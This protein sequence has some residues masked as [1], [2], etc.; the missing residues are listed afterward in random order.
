G[1]NSV[2][3]QAVAAFKP[4]WPIDVVTP[5]QWL[6][7][8][9][10]QFMEYQAIIIGDAGCTSGTSAFQAAID[11]RHLWGPVIDG[12]VVIIGTNSSTGLKPQI[13]RNGIEH[14]LESGEQFR[15]SLY[16]SLGCAYQDAAA[17]TVVTL[18]D[19]LGD[20]RVQ[21]SASSCAATQGHIFQMRPDYLSHDLDDAYLG[22]GG[23]AARSAFT[24]Y[25]MKNFA[26]VAIGLNAPG[27]Q[28]Y[29]DYTIDEPNPVSFFGTPY[30]LVR[31]ALSKGSG[32]GGNQDNVPSGEECD[33]GDNG[34]GSPGGWGIPPSET[35][36]YSCRRNWCGDGQ[37]DV[38]FGEECDNGID[39][40]RTRDAQGDLINGMCTMSCKIVNLYHP[41]TALCR[42]VT[43]AAPA[44]ACGA[45][46]DINNGSTDPDDDL[47]SCTQSPAGPYNIGNTLVTL[48][49]TDA[50]NQ[51][52]Q[53]TGTVTVRDVTGPAVSIGTPNRTLQCN[54][55]I[56]YADLSDVTVSELC[57]NP[58]SSIVRSGSVP[59]GM[60]GTYPLTYTAR[61]AANNPGSA[62]RTVNVV[63]T[64]VPVIN[65][66]LP[67]HMAVECGGTFTD[68]GYNAID[69]C[70][71][72]LTGSVTREGTVN[73]AAVGQYPLRYNL[74]DPSGN[75]AQERIR[76]VN[77]ND[78]RAPSLTVL[79][80]L[81][82]SVQCNHT[83]YA[84]PGATAM[85]S[86]VGDLTAAIQRTG[87]VNTGAVGTYPL[88]YRVRDPSGHE[89]TG[90]RTVAVHDTLA[91][92]IQV[93]PG[94]SVI[95]CNGTPY[96]D[97][98][99][100]ASDLCTGDLTQSISV[101]S[102]LIQT[103]SGQYTVT[104]RVAD[105]S[106]NVTTAVRQ[107]T[108]G[109]CFVCINLRLNDY[110][111]FLLEDYT[112]GHDVVGKVAAGGNI[113][114]ENF[115]VGH[116]QLDNDISNILV[117]GGNLHL[118]RGSI[119]GDARYGGTY[120]TNP[121]VVYPR[122]SASQGTPINFAARFAEL[123]AQSANLATLPAN[124]T[125]QR[126][127]WGGIMMHG[128]STD[129]NFFDVNTSAFNGAVLWNI[130][131][132]AGS[133]VVVNIYGA[134]A[135]FSGFGINFAGGIDQHGV[136]FNFVD[137]T[138]ITAQGFGFWGTV[139][140]PYAHI[141]FTSGSF[142]GGI[143]AKSFHGNA[144]GHINPL[145]NRDICP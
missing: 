16:V 89:A 98:G 30:V 115:S 7:M 86:C 66:N 42:D 20:F 142:D 8:T 125:T 12:D 134:S 124:G 17:N 69:V 71:G 46:A 40:G 108:V 68:P 105:A 143:Y 80:P 118:N 126:E 35:C 92:Q 93:L 44:S 31:G 34:N 74:R 136:L 23:C 38:E 67:T 25:P 141:N 47:V 107:L 122:G 14:V 53:C 2:E 73:P 94:P 29:I 119:W 33:R 130:E 139:L 4:G 62:T 76:T 15:T 127:A 104:Y 39:N 41:P 103:R 123:R 114:M 3:A 95:Q 91:P 111:L 19:Q 60:P 84:D 144:E 50:Q 37:V 116:G 135:N 70:A 132:P 79:G 49:C 113:T 1:L 55:N 48:T 138:S 85:D 65:L 100:T 131:A 81:S 56:S 110:N 117:A 78:T 36:S 24:T 109:R 128:T 77:V 10:I 27:N 59:M 21:G 88:S 51:M 5:A 99:A 22:L 145:N 61:D 64:V 96:V 52:A 43:V 112:G 121:S 97:P 6:A 133:L 120:S 63:D 106:G 101:S 87:S 57:S 26:V 82:Q 90:S 102:N 72:T 129:V 18:L 32:C 137:A 58:V 140:A 45:P 11:T 9:P 13:T 54:R 83:P 75:A 28:E